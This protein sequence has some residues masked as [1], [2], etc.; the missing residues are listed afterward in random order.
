MHVWL[1]WW[2]A[3]FAAVASATSDASG[4]CSSTV[5]VTKTTDP[6]SPTSAPAVTVAPDDSGQFTAIGDG[7]E[8]A[9]KN[10]IPTVTVLAGTYPAVT[11][12]A[13]PAVAVIGETESQYDYSQNKVV[14]SAAGTALTVLA[15][16]AGL[17]F[18]NINFINTGT[19]GSAINLKGNEIAFYQS[20]IISTGSAGVTANSA[21]VLIAN[22][23][24]EAPTRLI[25]GDANIY[26]FNTAIVPTGNSA[27]IVYS[28]GANSN[29]RSTV[30]VDRSTISRKP[31]ADN[32][33]VD[34]AAAYGTGSVAVYKESVLGD[35][36][37]PRG[38]HIDSTTQN[39]NNLY[40]EYGTTGA[41][42]YASNK[43]ARSPYVKLLTSSDLSPFTLTSVLTGGDPAVAASSTA[44]IEPNILAAIDSADVIGPSKASTGDS[45]SNDGSDSDS[46][47]GSGSSSANDGSGSG[48]S[49]GD[50]SDDG[51]GSGNGAG[52]SDGSGS[53]SSGNGSDDE[54]GSGSASGDSDSAMMHLARAQPLARAM[55]LEL[56]LNQHQATANLAT[57]LQ[58]QIQDQ[59][60]LLATVAQFQVQVRV[61]A[62]AMDLDHP[63]LAQMMA[64]P[65]V[66]A[67]AMDRDR[68]QHLAT[69]TQ[70]QARAMDL[71]MAIAGLEIA[72]VDPV[73]MAQVLLARVMVRGRG[74]DRDHQARGH[75]GMD[76]QEMDLA[77][78]AQDQALAMA[79]DPAMVQVQVHQAQD[80]AITPQVQALAMAL[81]Q[82][83]VQAQAHQEMDLAITAQAQA[84][85][86]Q[87]TDLAI[88][89]QD[90]ALAMALDPAMVQVQVHQ[91]QDLAITPQV[92]AL[93]MAPDRV[94]MAQDQALAMALDQAMVQAQAHQEMDLAITAQARDQTLAMA[95][96]PAVV[97][98][99]AHQAQNLAITPQ[100]QALAMALDQAVVQAQ[101]QA[102]QEMDLAITAQAQA[103]DHQET[104]LAIT[105]QVQALPTALDPAMVQAQ[106][107]AQARD[108][109]LAMALDPAMVRVQAQA[110]DRVITAQD[111]ALAM[112]LD[113]AVVQVRDHQEMDLA[114]TAQAQARDHQE[115]DLAITAQDQALAM[116]LDPAMVQV[117]VHQAQDLAI[118]PQVQALAMAPDRVIMAQDQALAMALDQ[119]MVQAQAWDQTLAMALDP[120]MDQAL[121]QALDQAVVQA[122]AHQE[123]DLAITA[124]AQDPVT[125]AQDHQE[126]DRLGGWCWFKRRLILY[127]CRFRVWFKFRLFDQLWFGSRIFW[128]FRLELSDAGSSSSTSSGNGSGSNESGSGSGSGSSSAGGGEGSG[129][130]GS[131]PDSS[132][133]SGS[134]SASSG[135]GNGD[136]SGSGSSSSGESGNG[137]DSGAGSGSDSAGSGSDSASGSGPGPSS[138]SGSSDGSGSSSTFVVSP[139][140]SKGQFKDVSAALAALPNDGKPYT[141]SVQSGL[142]KGQ[143]SVA[144]KGKVTIRGQTSNMNDYAQNTVTIEFT[145]GV[146]TSANQQ[147]KQSTAV[148]STESGDSESSLALY[149]INFKNPFGKTP[150]SVA[151]AADFSGTVAAYGCA[152]IGNQGTLF[153]NKGK[154]VISNSYIQGSADFIWGSS[155]A[156]LHQS[157]IASN[158]PGGGIVAQSRPSEKASGGIVSDASFVTYTDSYGSSSR[159]VSRL[160]GQTYLGRPVTE[161]SRVVYMHSFLDKHINPLGWT[162][163]PP[164]SP[165]TDHVLFGEYENTGQG[166]SLQDRALF[167]ANMTHSEAQAYSLSRW[168]GNTAWLDMNAYNSPPSFDLTGA[169]GRPPLPGSNSTPTVTSMT[170]YTTTTSAGV[171]STV[172]STITVEVLPDPVTKTTTT[173]S[174]TSTTTTFTGLPVT[175][176]K[177]AILTLDLGI[178]TI[179]LGPKTT[180]NNISNAAPSTTSHQNATK[181]LG[182]IS[183]VTN[184][185]TTYQS[186]VTSTQ[187]STSVKIETF[188]PEP[189]NLIS[190]VTTLVGIGGTVT[191]SVE[192]VTVV[193]SAT[194]TRT[195]TKVTTTTLMCTP[196]PTEAKRGLLR[197][198]STA[199]AATVTDKSITT[200]IVKTSTITTPIPTSYTTRMISK[201][202][203]LDPKTTTVTV[204]LSI[205]SIWRDA[206]YIWG[207][208]H[209]YPRPNNLRILL[210]SHRHKN[211]DCDVYYHAN[212][213]GDPNKDTISHSDI[214]L[215]VFIDAICENGFHDHDYDNHEDTSERHLLP[216]M[217]LINTP[218][219][220]FAIRL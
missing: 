171:A 149:N 103:R 162:A 196:L 177:T 220:Y 41:G 95:L 112:R 39:D 142:Y 127:R 68:D 121:A 91:A 97:Q 190:T 9:Q 116:A 160:D 152:F 172:I 182:E 53:G 15:N 33:D 108:Q 208:T 186:T 69:A 215:H 81:D 31:G 146:S 87:E 132:E 67:L 148:I 90:Q 216:F 203:T 76:H 78:T 59:D 99:Q 153:L 93:A 83:V 176:T 178:L 36:I 34:L 14:I 145:K 105:A 206:I 119:A 211:S 66:Q 173:K 8:Y 5:Y 21:V 85:D 139:N 188:H 28:K 150:N 13:T 24:I 80:L 25:Y 204:T 126:M 64:L 1:V 52:P 50:S 29:D 73:T 141:I 26:I 131:G 159:L 191:K 22:G 17:T 205:K 35:L 174:T 48:S 179:Q 155:T 124:Q 113:Q 210:N 3:V 156:F 158:F 154:Q 184:T 129:D 181:S 23:Y 18:E 189:Q 43:D 198:R 135:N 125:A 82:A 193:L 101:A 157:V 169:S 2:L 134:S 51:S 163:G 111:Q 202:R 192:D 138:G 147:Q 104:D 86:H 70:V 72:Q 30:V 212:C 4:T 10:K 123:M 6:N 12:S 57:A 180:A 151:L 60:Q 62:L 19:S 218:Y 71:A 46:G 213:I 167:A 107:Q 175:S 54:S 56:D 98:A 45:G 143:I 136:S 20:Q 47:P 79:L 88:T 49:D 200:G 61:Q 77:I 183:L 37:A 140:P 27:L 16:V 214:P 133:G 117:Q 94:I 170:S 7:I 168:I 32:V 122:Q 106:A 128:K 130:S 100:V 194:S 65:Q 11:V 115:T 137:G 185:M 164:G 102:H 40:G 55:D 207:D 110:Q 63:E 144:R 165:S 209:S 42:A 74:R 114:I 118:T 96:D 187:I 109:T 166:S 195:L 44:W 89:A 161:Y 58:V 199:L 38:V 201:T 217:N 120:A 75:R 197:P 92:Q 84:R 219:T